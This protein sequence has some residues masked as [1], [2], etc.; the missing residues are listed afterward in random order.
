[1]GAGPSEIDAAEGGWALMGLSSPEGHIFEGRT[2][3]FGGR[4]K[5]GRGEGL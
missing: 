2:M 4:A 5:G 3:E 1:M